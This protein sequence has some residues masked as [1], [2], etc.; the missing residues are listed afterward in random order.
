[1][2][3][4][5]R[6]GGAPAAQASKPTWPGHRKPLSPLAAECGGRGQK[7]GNGMGKVE[8][9]S[10]TDDDDVVAPAAAICEWQATAM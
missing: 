7:L 4:P 8:K 10:A 1:M 6:V 5:D 3:E 2:A 9:A